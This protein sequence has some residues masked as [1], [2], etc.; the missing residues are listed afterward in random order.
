MLRKLS[1]ALI[2]LEKRASI[3]HLPPIG[4]S[5]W[6]PDHLRAACKMIQAPWGASIFSPNFPVSRNA[7]SPG[8]AGCLEPRAPRRSQACEAVRLAYRK[9]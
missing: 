1:V 4:T 5:I 9:I 8:H 6:V 3:C 7:D 2:D